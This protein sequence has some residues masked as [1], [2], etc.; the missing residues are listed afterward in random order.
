M[1]KKNTQVKSKSSEISP[2][3]LCTSCANCSTLK[4]WWLTFDF[5]LFTLGFTFLPPDQHQRVFSGWCRLPW[6][7]SVAS[8]SQGS[9][10]ILQQSV[11]FNQWWIGIKGPTKHSTHYYTSSSSSSLG[12]W[13][14][15]GWFH[16]FMQ[17][18]PNYEP[19]ICVPHRKSRFIRPGCVFLDFNRSSFWPVPTAASEFFLAAAE[20]HPA[21]CLTCCS[22][23]P[24]LF[25]DP[26]KRWQHASRGAT[27]DLT[28][29][30][31]MQI[32]TNLIV[33][34]KDQMRCFLAGCGSQ[35]WDCGRPPHIEECAENRETQTYFWF[36]MKL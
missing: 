16:G 34:C 33:V 26:I 5:A 17:L 19:T 2:G 4:V 30:L 35:C 13:H 23:S 27:L 15:A 25:S 22:L 32:D 10:P 12:C 9:S 6:C 11:A 36:F 21:W 29:R 20:A 28:P 1:A 18:T 24:C 14:K 31:N 3:F 8:W 7:K